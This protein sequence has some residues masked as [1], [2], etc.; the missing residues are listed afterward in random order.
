MRVSDFYISAYVLAD[1]G[2]DV[3]LSNMRG[4]TY[5]RGHKTLNPDRD[6]KYWDFSYVYYYLNLITMYY[7]LLKSEV[8]TYHCIL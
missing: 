7:N 6:Q 8:D 3:W 1:A 2:Y 4:N 5:S